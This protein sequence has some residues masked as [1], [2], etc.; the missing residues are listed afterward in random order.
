[1]RSLAIVDL[2]NFALSVLDDIRRCEE[3]CYNQRLHGVL[4]VTQ[5]VTCSQVARVLGD[6][7][8]TLVSR[9]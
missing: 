1:M 8:R 2:A 7:R 3:S 5:G 9:L 6:S 4:P